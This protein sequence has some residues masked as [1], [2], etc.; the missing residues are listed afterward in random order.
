MQTEK[1]KGEIAIR[2]GFRLE[3]SVLEA[4]VVCVGKTVELFFAFSQTRCFL[5][6]ISRSDEIQTILGERK[7]R[8]F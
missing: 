2:L 3:R 7:S 8:K 4:T 5:W 1:E 6:V